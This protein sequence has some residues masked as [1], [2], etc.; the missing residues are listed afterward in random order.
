MVELGFTFFTCFHL[1]LLKFLP[2]SRYAVFQCIRLSLL[3]PDCL[4]LEVPNSRADFTIFPPSYAWGK[5]SEIG[6]TFYAD[7]A[8]TDE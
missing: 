1:F 7:Q 5:D 2:L 8:P 6:E 3:M 4:A